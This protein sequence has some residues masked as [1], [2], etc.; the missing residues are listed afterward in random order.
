MKSILTSL[1]LAGLLFAAAPAT[2]AYAVESKGEAA[3][4][5]PEASAPKVFSAP[6]K[7]GTKATCPVTGEQFAIAKDTLHVEHKGKH[8]YFCCPGCKKSFDKDPDKYTK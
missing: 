5:K 3:A 7:V 8:V 6:Q 1:C 4:P 2:T